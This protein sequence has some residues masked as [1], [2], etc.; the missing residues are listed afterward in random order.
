M[1]DCV[2]EKKKNSFAH[3]RQ[4]DACLLEKQHA[5]FGER[6]VRLSAKSDGGC[7]A[8]CLGRGLGAAD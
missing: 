3:P 2:T 8:G 6:Q 4:G 1:V 7:D 5:L